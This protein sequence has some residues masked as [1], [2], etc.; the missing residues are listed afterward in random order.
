[1]RTLKSADT[2]MKDRQHTVTHK[3]HKYLFSNQTTD[4]REYDRK[5]TTILI[6][7]LQ[8]QSI[9]SLAYGSVQQHVDKNKTSMKVS[10]RAHKVLK[11][12]SRRQHF[13]RFVL[14]IKVASRIHY[15]LRN[16]TAY[17]QFSSRKRSTLA[18]DR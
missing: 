18:T 2:A 10:R 1:M 8:I 5:Y 14:F 6:Y 12:R 17:L 7:G 9:L 3:L 15:V 4:A 11:F 16:G 13:W